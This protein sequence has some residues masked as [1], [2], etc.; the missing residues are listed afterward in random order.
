LEIF[1][2]NGQLLEA[3]SADKLQGRV[4]PSGFYLIRYA[5]TGTKIYV[6]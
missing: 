4:L 3:N 6:P 1:R 2:L 5:G